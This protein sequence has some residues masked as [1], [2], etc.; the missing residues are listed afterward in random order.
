MSTVPSPK[1]KAELLAM[2][3]EEVA[4]YL[5]AGGNWADGAW[6]DRTDKGPR[7]AELPVYDEL[8][9]TSVRL[10]AEMLGWLAAEAG[11]DREGKSGIIRQALAE[12]RERHG[13]AA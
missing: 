3:E 8:V 5:D 9:T 11:R 12:W 1:T 4:A 13:T 2:T 10:P 7:P 6:A